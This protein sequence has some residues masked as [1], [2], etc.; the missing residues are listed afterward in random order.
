[1]TA[2]A[3]SSRLRV[4]LVSEAVTLAQVARPHVPASAPDPRIFDVT[5]EQKKRYNQLFGDLFDA[6]RPIGTIPTEDV[7]SVPA[8]GRPVYSAE[9]LEGYV[10]EDL[11]VLESVDPDVVVGD[12]RLSLRVS[13]ALAGKP[14]VA[15]SNAH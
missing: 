2:P 9:T 13:A 8:R 5:T 3:R 10:R 4:L 6:R 7:L 15:I 11:A 14:H 1:M 12:F